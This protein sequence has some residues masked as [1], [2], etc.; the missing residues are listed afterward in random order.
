MECKIIKKENDEIVVFKN[1]V[2]VEDDIE[3]FSL[4]VDIYKDNNITICFKE[5]T[6][7]RFFFYNLED[8]DIVTIDMNLSNNISIKSERT[9]LYLLG[10][11]L[12]IIINGS[13]I[14]RVKSFS[15]DLKTEIISIICST[16]QFPNNTKD[17]DNNQIKLKGFKLSAEMKG[18]GDD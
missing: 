4:N 12:V 1:G 16:S 6:S 14:G 3:N 9:S 11:N 13:P 18:I 8:K 5:K 2:K 15:F 10:N 7:G 17:F